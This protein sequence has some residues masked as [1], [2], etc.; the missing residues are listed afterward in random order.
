M[1]IMICVNSD[2]PIPV[3]LYHYGICAT[4][5]FKARLYKFWENHDVR[6]YDTIGKLTYWSPE[7]IVQ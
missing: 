5:T 7:V 2:S 3:G 1:F 4:N 6:Q